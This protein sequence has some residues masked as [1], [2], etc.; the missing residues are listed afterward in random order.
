VQTILGLEPIAF[1]LDRTEFRTVTDLLNF[2]PFVERLQE[3][4]NRLGL[5]FQVKNDSAT[6]V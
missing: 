5:P 4:R 1:V 3:I 2:P 6:Q